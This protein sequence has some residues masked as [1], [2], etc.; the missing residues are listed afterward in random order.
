SPARSR[1]SAT[2]C[3]RLDADFAPRQTLRAVAASYFDVDG[4]LVKTNLIPPTLWYLVHQRTPLRSLQKLARAAWKSPQMI[5]AE[6]QDRRMCT[7]VLCSSYEGISKDRLHILADEAFD[8]VLK[9]ILYPNAKD[10][11]SRCR[12]EGHD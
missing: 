10:L 4:T 11:V 9:G 3:A 6:L 2:S 12:D 7:E 1:G 8:T 5:W